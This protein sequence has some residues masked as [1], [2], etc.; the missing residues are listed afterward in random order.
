MNELTSVTDKGIGLGA[1]GMD[2]EK[3][4]S[5]AFD[6][7]DVLTGTGTSAGKEKSSIDELEET[8][9]EWDAKLDLSGESRIL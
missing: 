8:M 9:D 2:N 3:S 5:E 7:A 4:T 6:K 1:V